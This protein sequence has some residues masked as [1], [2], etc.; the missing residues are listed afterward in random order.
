M[1]GR[2]SRREVR[3]MDILMDILSTPWLLRVR[4][5]MEMKR[6]AP[7][8]LQCLGLL[9]DLCVPDRST[10]SH[11]DLFHALDTCSQLKFGFN[12]R[13]LGIRVHFVAAS[14]HLAQLYR[15][16]RKQQQQ[17]TLMHFTQVP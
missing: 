8:R 3:L 9:S 7:R 5:M 11:T 10:A 17:P 13:V 15:P 12:Y 1:P 4:T 14:A 6:G 16:S 2:G